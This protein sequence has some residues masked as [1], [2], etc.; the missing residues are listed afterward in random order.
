MIN[1]ELSAAT[2]RP[3]V[4]SILA[5]GDSYGY[6][7][8]KTVRERS[9]EA[10][11]WEEG[12]LYPVLH[13][14]E[15]EGLLT[16]YWKRGETGRRRKYYSLNAAGHRELADSKNQWKAAASLLTGIWGGEPCLT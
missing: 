3:A 14:L 2:I 4:L 7:I 8:V 10:I 6:E 5:N 9:N 12:V 16:S 15:R 11:E 13:R 1:K